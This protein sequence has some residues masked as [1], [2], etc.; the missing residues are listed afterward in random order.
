ML[1]LGEGKPSPRPPP[2]SAARQ[3]GRCSFL[4]EALLGGVWGR[5]CPPPGKHRSQKKAG[6]FLFRKF[7]MS[8]PTLYILMGNAP[9]KV[10]PGAA[11]EAVER[12]SQQHTAVCRLFDHGMKCIHHCIHTMYCIQTCLP[13]Y[14]FE[15]WY[16]CPCY[17]HRIVVHNFCNIDPRCYK[18]LW[19]HTGQPPP[20]R[21][22]SR[23]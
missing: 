21:R 23:T 7:L 15:R 8:G 2:K 1:F 22:I 20:V 16:W 10:A 11:A 5:A 9:L 14:H 4:R 19:A 6:D 18:A 13:T 17:I 3:E 12:L